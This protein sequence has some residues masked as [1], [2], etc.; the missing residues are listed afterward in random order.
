MFP[1]PD[2]SYRRL[3]SCYKRAEAFAKAGEI[4]SKHSL[5]AAWSNCKLMMDE[6]ASC[7]NILLLDWFASLVEIHS[8][9]NILSGDTDLAAILFEWKELMFFNPCLIQNHKENENDS[10]T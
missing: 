8:L 6:Q 9:K 3:S 4:N 10:K 1:S 2:K 7:F 5:A